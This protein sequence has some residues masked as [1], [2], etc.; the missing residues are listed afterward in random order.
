MSS[1]YVT[2]ETP[3]GGFEKIAVST[4]VKQITATNLA[5]NEVGGLVKR[6]CKAF[7]TVETNSIRVRWDG[8][9][10]DSTTG[11]LLTSGS[12][13]TIIGESNV[14]R[15]RMI[16]ASADADVHVTFYYNR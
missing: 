11:H 3:A 8:T 10:P 4:T 12:S 1:S 14:S 13:L 15:L 7:L 16:R 9:N 5:V 2:D 6:A